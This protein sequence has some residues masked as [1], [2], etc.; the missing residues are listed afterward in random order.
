MKSQKIIYSTLKSSITKIDEMSHEI[1]TSDK[2][3]AKTVIK[4]V[5]EQID[6]I[7][8]SITSINLDKEE[9]ESDDNKYNI[10]FDIEKTR[11]DVV[12]AI[13]HLSDE[14]D[15]IKEALQKIVSSEKNIVNVASAEPEILEQA[16]E[17][18]EE[19]KSEPEVLEQ[20]L[21]SVEEEKS[22]PEVL[23]QALESVEEEK[24][25]PEILEQALESVEEE[26][27]EPEVLEQ[28]LESVE[29][30]TQEKQLQISD[31][32]LSN[33]NRELSPDEIAALFASMGA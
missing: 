11:Q 22:E 1:V 9:K 8:S 12:N 3:I 17:T 27:S 28:A 4:K 33:P 13:N 10:A 24:S 25:E 31:I 21:E 16:L 29:E 7:K 2:V 15:I 19:E 23:E 6:D 18:V 32:D 30:E 14:C 20:A 5:S 26:K